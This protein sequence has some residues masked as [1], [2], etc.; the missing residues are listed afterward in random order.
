MYRY[1][2]ILY[3]LVHIIG[4]MQDILM[5]QKTHFLSGVL[6]YKKMY[7]YKNTRTLLRKINT[8]ITPFQQFCEKLHVL[9]YSLFQFVWRMFLEYDVILDDTNKKINFNTL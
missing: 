4:N 8:I 2:Q 9:L 6:L 5:C 1:I 7:K 3:Y